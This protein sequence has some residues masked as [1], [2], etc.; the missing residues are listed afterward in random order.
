MFL[1]VPEVSEGL[2]TVSNK[3]Q[4]KMNQPST[5]IFALVRASPITLTALHVYRCKR[6]S[7]L[8]FDMVSEAWQLSS[9]LLI[10]YFSDS[11]ISSS[12]RYQRICGRGSPV[13]EVSNVADCPKM[14]DMSLT[15]WL[16]VGP[17]EWT[18]TTVDDEISPES[19]NTRTV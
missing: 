10:L 3:Q 16:K 9:M 2:K 18:L 12:S 17:E 4:R 8:T 14:A 7:A 19:L 11:S 5:R 1:Q 6:S 13:T 15:G